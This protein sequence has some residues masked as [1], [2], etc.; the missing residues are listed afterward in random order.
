[1]E[2]EADSNLCIDTDSDTADKKGAIKGQVKWTQEEVSAKF[3]S[4]SSDDIV[5]S[6]SPSFTI[7]F[8]EVAMTKM[9]FCT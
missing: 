2:E 3:F 6:N 9:S 4:H 7:L 8:T 5:I 1:M